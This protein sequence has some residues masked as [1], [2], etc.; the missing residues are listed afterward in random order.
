MNLKILNIIRYRT[1]RQ[2]NDFRSRIERGDLITILP[3]QFWTHCNVVML[4]K[5]TVRWRELQQKRALNHKYDNTTI[6]E[7]TT[8]RCLSKYHHTLSYLRVTASSNLWPSSSCF[9]ICWYPSVRWHI[10]L[11]LVY[12]LV[13][14]NCHTTLSVKRASATALDTNRANQET[15]EIGLALLTGRT[16]HFEPNDSM[17]LVVAPFSH[18]SNNCHV[19]VTDMVKG[20][21]VNPCVLA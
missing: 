4:L 6:M 19:N 10:K 20:N 14:T 15:V 1:G 8:I 5:V 9:G 21:V 13:E 3:M 11:H 7:R 17:L 18:L 12:S 2:C 16:I